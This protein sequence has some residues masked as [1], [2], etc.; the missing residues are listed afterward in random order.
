MITPKK[1]EGWEDLLFNREDRSMNW[2][3]KKGRKEENL[4]GWD[5]LI[6]VGTVQIETIQV[7]FRSS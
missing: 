7:N 3:L 4:K 6:N 2:I 1:R 5:F